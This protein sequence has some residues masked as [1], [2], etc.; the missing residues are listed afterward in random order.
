MRKFLA[1]L[2]IS[3]LVG[4]SAQSIK[5]NSESSGISTVAVLPASIPS[6]VAREK[7]EAIRSQ[8]IEQ[9]KNSGFTV[10]T[11][12]IVK[13][14]CTD[15]GCGDQVTFAKK[16]G[17][18]G[19]VTLRVKSVSRTNLLAAFY[20]SIN[21]E[22]DLVDPSGKQISHIEHIE[23]EKGGLLFNSGQ[24]FQGLRSTAEN[25]EQ[26]SFT[27]LAE[28]FAKAVSL[29]LPRA[30]SN[31][32][33]LTAQTDIK[34]NSVN[35]SSLGESRYR[36][37]AQGT[38]GAQAAIIID[39]SKGVLREE[40]SGE[41]CGVFPIGG[42][43]PENTKV[44]IELRSP[45]GVSVQKRLDQGIVFGC[46]PEGLL[47]VSDG[48]LVL[49]CKDSEASCAKKIEICRDNRLYVFKA[50]TESGPYT[51]EGTLSGVGSKAD[52][53]YTYAVLPV[54]KDGGSSVPVTLTKG[55]Q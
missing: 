19:F 23:S 3:I 54:G 4:C 12:S 14:G 9:L 40:R 20:N 6:D 51:R 30:V 45:F 37:C 41:Y 42:A 10:L 15:T 31:A 26:A 11:D 50:A 21:G 43:L 48:L 8:V 35:T 32:E 29:E 36:I 38:P 18:E 52:Q 44:A 39:R 25:T 55:A 5:P 13:N 49:R 27:R 24:V 46:M 16:Y 34:I 22:V 28:K 17:V 47:T 2:A 33:T 53:Q 7:I 1:L